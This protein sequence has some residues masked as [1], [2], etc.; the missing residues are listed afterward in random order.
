MNTP[1]QNDSIWKMLVFLRMICKGKETSLKKNSI[2]KKQN[3]KETSIEKNHNKI[4]TMQ[5]NNVKK[6]PIKQ[7]KKKTR[8][9]K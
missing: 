9:K 6:K 7:K 5:K 2:N 4:K 8:E 1:Q 3:Q